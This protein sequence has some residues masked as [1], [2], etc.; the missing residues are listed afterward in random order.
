MACGCTDRLNTVNKRLDNNTQLA[1]NKTLSLHSMASMSIDEIINLYRQGYTLEERSIENNGYINSLTYVTECS[2]TGTQTVDKSNSTSGFNLTLGMPHAIAQKFTPTSLCLQSVTIRAKQVFSGSAGLDVYITPDVSGHPD[3][4]N[5]MGNR[6]AK[7]SKAYDQ[8][9]I[10]YTDLNFVLN[11]KLN[12]LN[13]LWIVV[14]PS[15][16]DQNTDSGLSYIDLE[17]GNV[18]TSTTALKVGTTDWSLRSGD[19]LVYKTWKTTY[20][21]L[22]VLSSI[23]VSPASAPVNVGSSSQ[24][25]AICKDQNSA[26]MTCQT[27]TWTSTDTSKATVDPSGL[28]TGVATGTTNITATYGSVTSNSSTITVSSVTP[29]LTSI[30]VSPASASASVGSMTQLTATCKDQNNSTMTCPTLTWLSSNTLKATVDS[31]GRVTGVAA[32]TAGMT[33]RYGSVIS[34]SS[35][36]TV[37]SVDLVLTSISPE[38]ITLLPNATQQFTARDQYVNAINTGVTWAKITGVGSI[39]T[40]GLYSAGAT[41]G[42]AI[43]SATYSD[44]TITAPITVSTTLPSSEGGAGMLL[45]L[46]GVVAL[47][48]MMSAK[49]PQ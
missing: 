26:T 41:V 48:I 44:V 24:L 21:P 7:V 25:T 37:P 6:L 40:S 30:V 16:Y 9:P 22:P 28:V 45:G 23:V 47:G 15:V 35:T 34:N 14:T 11:L 49:K 39:D 8:V 32:G 1:N 5:W 17:D 38:S 33:A 20:T 43:I 29:V 19:S 12:N 2:G 3:H 4:S 36:I 10:T 13:P 46:V 31:T 42:T 18:A 27:L